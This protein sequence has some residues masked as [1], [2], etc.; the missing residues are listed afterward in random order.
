MLTKWFKAPLTPNRDIYN[1]ITIVIAFDSIHDDFETKTSS[2]LKTGDKTID[3]I[4]QILYSAE[5]KNFSKQATGVTNNVAMSFRGP[6][7]GYNNNYSL[8]EKQKANSNEQC[9][10]CHKMGHFGR[11]CN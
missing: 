10:N 9:F 2:L 8:E 3:K 1:S 7:V 6:Q 5:A 4:Q 11:D